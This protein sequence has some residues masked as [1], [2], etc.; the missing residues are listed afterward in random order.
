[1]TPK[2]MTFNDLNGHIAIKS[3]SGSAFNGLAIW[4]SEKTLRKFAELCMSAAI[5][6]VSQRL[7]WRYSLSVMGLFIG[8]TRR[9]SV[10][11]SRP[12]A[13]SCH[14]TALAIIDFV[15]SI[16]TDDITRNSIHYHA[17]EQQLTCSDVPM[18]WS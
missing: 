1:M 6:T 4:L 14:S 11:L 15:T 3:V 2:R 5:Q 10:T 18:V 7:Y 13:G 12:Y 17:T 8:V 9:G 16:M